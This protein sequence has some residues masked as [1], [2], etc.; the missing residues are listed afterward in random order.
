MSVRNRVLFFAVAWAIVLMPF[1]FWRSTWFGRPLS[2]EQMQQYLRDD[3]KPR[4][5]QHALVQIGEMMTRRAPAAQRWY[6]DLV[7][8][9]AHPV[10]EVRNTD[11]WVMGQDNR[12]EF[13]SALLTMLQDASPTVRA[14]AALSLIRY[15]DASGRPALLAMLQPA[16]VS[17]P[18]SG[19][20]LDLGKTG[21]AIH[22]NGVVAK[23]EAGSSAIEIRSPIG[24][25]IRSFTVAEGAQ[26]SSGSDI[27]TIDPG[28]EEVW[29]ALR[30][31]YLIGEKDDLPAIRAYQRALP[32][33]PD[34][35]RQQAIETEKAI[36]KR[37]PQ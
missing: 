33:M 15:G 30:G 29:E 4:D 31:L 1:L 2:P 10:E 25:R 18:Q 6:P 22:E 36:L 26:V 9:S 28:E 27:A 20:V 37:A 23:L 16:T 11:A 17:A 12:P 24:G 14:N 35:V 8:L 13:H 34:R 7:R 21:A 32:D 5:I 19:R 3:K